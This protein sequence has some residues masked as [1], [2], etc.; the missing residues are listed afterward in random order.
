M[1]MGFG[2]NHTVYVHASGE[3]VP[4]IASAARSGTLDCDICNN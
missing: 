3:V 1:H 2:L 4:W